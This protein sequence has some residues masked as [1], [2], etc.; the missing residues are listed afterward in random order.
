M[1]D[2]SDAPMMPAGPPSRGLDQPR[3]QEAVALTSSRRL[4]KR[5]YIFVG[6]PSRC[7]PALKVASFYS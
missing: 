7:L 3:D 6:A 1:D 5:S 4:R 2:V